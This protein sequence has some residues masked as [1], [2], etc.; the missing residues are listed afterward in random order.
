MDRVDILTSTFGKALGGAAACTSTRKL[1]KILHQRSRTILF[2]NSLPPMGPAPALYVLRI[3][4]TN[5][6]IIGKNWKKILPLPVPQWENWVLLGGDGKHPIIPVMLMEEK[7]AAEMAG[8]LFKKGIYVHGFTYPVVPKG[9]PASASQ[10]SAAHTKAKHSG[11][12]EVQRD[13]NN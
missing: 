7:L 9:K 2:S 3:Q 13:E 12:P 10:I 5:L 8:A 4:I 11:I 6:L 1:S